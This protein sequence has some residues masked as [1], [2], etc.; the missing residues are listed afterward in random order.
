L[1]VTAQLMAKIVSIHSYRGG[2]GKSNITANLAYVLAQQGKR[3]AVD[4][5]DIQSPG[6]H[7]IFQINQELLKHSLNDFLWRKCKIEEVAIP[8]ISADTGLPGVLFLVPS[9]TNTGDIARIINDGYNMDLLSEG[10]M[11]LCEKLELDFL[12]VDTHP[13]LNEETLLSIAISDK[14][15]IIMRPDQQD[16]E[17]SSITLRIASRLQVEEIAVILNKVPT[18]YDLAGLK[19]EVE[20][21]YGFPVEAVIPHSDELMVLG[22]KELFCKRFPEHP[23]SGLIRTVAERLI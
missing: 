19:A 17:G 1:K 8:V 12:L 3:V 10:F 7:V 5:T 22:S 23:V 4:D 16:F 2:T 14:L 6:I 21:S 13:G 9:S 18:S 20:K 15:L 11:Q